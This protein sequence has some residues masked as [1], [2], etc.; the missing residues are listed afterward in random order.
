MNKIRIGQVEYAESLNRCSR[1]DP[2][3]IPR[4]AGIAI[5]D[6]IPCNLMRQLYGSTYLFHSQPASRA[7]AGSALNSL[8]EH[9]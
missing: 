7:F 3:A 1:A 6:V 2:S 8:G 9:Q 5:A 4:S